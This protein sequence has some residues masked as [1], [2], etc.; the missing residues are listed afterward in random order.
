ML[1]A[2]MIGLSLLPPLSASGQSSDEVGEPPSETPSEPAIP[3]HPRGWVGKYV[4]GEY[5]VELRRTEAGLACSTGADELPVTPGLNGAMTA[6][7]D[8]SRVR[9]VF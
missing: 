9:I 6:T 2:L 3:V 4:T 5:K 1:A 8:D 7:K